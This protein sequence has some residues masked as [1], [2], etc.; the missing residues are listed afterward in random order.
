MCQPT[1][2]KK[3]ALLTCPST[4]PTEEWFNHLE[5]VHKFLNS[6][7]MA[8]DDADVERLVKVAVL[9]TGID[10]NHP[11]LAEFISDGRLDPGWDFVTDRPIVDLD[12][13]GTHVSH[14]LLRTAPYVKLYPLR[15]FEST[16][17]NDHTR[18]I[19]STVRAARETLERFAVLTKIGRPSIMLSR[20]WASTSSTYP[21]LL[22]NSCPTSTMHSPTLSE[23]T[24]KTYSSLPPPPTTAT[25]S[26]TASATLPVTKAASSASARPRWP[27]TIGPHSVRTVMR[28]KPI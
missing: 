7:R 8:L 1:A 13:H 11:N 17:A 28:E 27:E 14:T 16:K 3:Y 18:N 15:V 2:G 21:Y 9:D 22:R 5:V 25:S 19:I 6:D 12:G 4:T 23:K 26:G 24:A 20:L 10:L